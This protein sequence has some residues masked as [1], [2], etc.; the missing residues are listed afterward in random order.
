MKLKELIEL[1]TYENHFKKR[2]PEMEVGVDVSRTFPQYGEDVPL[3]IREVEQFKTVTPRL[4]IVT[5][6]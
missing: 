4:R 6:E 5:K 3:E 2:D 1:L